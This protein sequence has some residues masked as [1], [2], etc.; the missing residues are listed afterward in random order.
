MLLITV[1]K[2]ECCERGTVIAIAPLPVDATATEK[3]RQPLSRHFRL[4]KGLA[5]AEMLRAECESPRSSD[6][7]A[8]AQPRHFEPHVINEHRWVQEH[9]P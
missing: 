3:T 2:R 8:A 1:S 5:K 6:R 4:R 7:L 9:Q